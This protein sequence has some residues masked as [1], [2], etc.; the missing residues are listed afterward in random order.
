MANNVF[1][2]D[3]IINR[4]YETISNNC[5]KKKFA[6]L[7]FENFQEMLKNYQNYSKKYNF[8]TFYQYNFKGGLKLHHLSFFFKYLYDRENF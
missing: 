2:I 1:K 6:D 3:K 4:H 7:C 8:K 5:Q